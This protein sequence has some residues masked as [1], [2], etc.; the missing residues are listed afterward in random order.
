MALAIPLL[1]VWTGMGVASLG[2]QGGVG[3]LIQQEPGAGFS[4]LLFCAW[5]LLSLRLLRRDNSPAAAE[6]E[7]VGKTASPEQGVEPNGAPTGHRKSIL[8]VD[9]N[10]VNR[11]V[12]GLMLSKAG[13]RVVEARDGREAVEKVEAGDHGL[14]LLD[15]HM[16]R[17]DGY[18][19]V[20]AIRALDGPNCEIPVLAMTA[21]AMTG[22]VD[23]CLEAGMNGYVSK[24][25]RSI[26]LLAAVESWFDAK[27][28]FGGEMEKAVQS[29][30]PPTPN[31][32][33]PTLNMDQL[34]ELRS[35]GGNDGDAILVELAET[36]MQGAKERLI[37]MDAAFEQD[38]RH[39]L[40]RSAH[41]LKGS[42][43]TLGAQRL[44]D[45]CRVLEENARMGVFP[46]DREPL[47]RIRDEVE[48]VRQALNLE[49]NG[50]AV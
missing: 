16:P 11:R 30:V 20:A 33:I 22:D 4:I 49:I 5:I 21:S 14:V 38:D 31:D 12:A 43:G 2:L 47:D 3:R 6:R 34:D 37:A 9:D 32:E 28:H 27:D 29:L 40:G 39:E 8:L 19:A 17:M 41:T 7:P 18:E 1:N 50:L 42:A 45:L 24:P 46:E 23:R 35:Y 10:A 25:V 13:Y 26:A 36:F 48:E 44:E 15:V